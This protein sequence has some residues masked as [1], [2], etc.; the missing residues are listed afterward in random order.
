MRLIDSHFHLDYYKNHSYWYSKINELQQYTLCVTNSPE[1]FHSCRRMYPETE[2]V[3]FALGYNPKSIFSVPFS[4]NAFM[5]EL[6]YARYIGEVGLDF[7]K[8]FVETKTKQLEIFDYICHISSS[9]GKV[10]SIHLKK[11]EMEALEILERNN[12]KKAILH[13]YS[14]ND[15][16]I[17]KFVEIGCYFSV[18]GSMCASSSGQKIISQI[19]TQRLLIESD[20]PFSKVSSARY[21]PVMLG[22]VYAQVESITKCLNLKEVV[23]NNF[24]TLL[25][26]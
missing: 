2:Y 12:I 7:S 18:N 14:G 16:L 26:K 23:Y 8:Q 21:T 25:K 19:P 15:A 22:D 3:R 17:E 4:R 13:W 6:N 10:M 20:G 5:H 1:I 11:S 9:F 24:A